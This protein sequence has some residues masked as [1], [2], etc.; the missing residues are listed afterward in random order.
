MTIFTTSETHNPSI[1]YYYCNWS[2]SHFSLHLSNTFLLACLII[3]SRLI[4]IPKY[5]FL[6]L[7]TH[8]QSPLL[9]EQHSLPVT[10]SLHLVVLQAVQGG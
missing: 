9:Q 7:Q 2:A 6:N 4:V 3:V 1:F 8:P 10:V 5:S